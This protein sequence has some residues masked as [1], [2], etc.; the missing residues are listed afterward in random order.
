MGLATE[1][2]RIDPAYRERLRACG[3]DTVRGVLE[4]VEG[5]VVAWSRTTDTLHV[6]GTDD[7]PGFYVK[8]YLYPTWRK[9]LRAA[10]RGTFFGLHRGQAEYRALDMM[11]QLGLPA[12]RAVACGGRRCAHF[13]TS[14]FLITEE[15]PEACNLTTFAQEVQSGRRV[16]S[17]AQR[18]A[19]IQELARQLAALHETGCSHGN[20]FW[21]N[22]LVRFGPDGR[23]EYFFLDA[24]PLRSWERL[25]R[26]TWWIRE[27]A[28]VL[29]S[30][31]QFTT[32]VEQVR[33][34]REYLGGALPTDWR[35]FAR[36]IARLAEG[37]RGHEARRVRMN[38]LF[39]EWNRTLAEEQ[40]RAAAGRPGRL[41]GA[42]GAGPAP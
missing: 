39:D 14:G 16:L 22:L 24:Q 29:V 33:F 12:V 7:Q 37:W 10:F 41:A 6:A 1:H 35:L 3:L 8:R 28:Q 21:R 38:L 5:R 17:R 18:R 23:P 2:M 27:L 30:A 36:Q 25:S 32:R 40:S 20:L 9:R 42:S 4:R 19:M 11:R 31:E 26:G 15:V 34:L 13:L